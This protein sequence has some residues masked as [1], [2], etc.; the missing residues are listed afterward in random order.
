MSANGTLLRTG[1]T[2]QNAG[3][4]KA[5][6]Y[7]NPARPNYDSN[8]KVLANKHWHTPAQPKAGG[9]ECTDYAE[10]ETSTRHVITHACCGAS[11]F[12]NHDILQTIRLGRSY[13]EDC[14]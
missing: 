12:G 6:N 11:D 1:I 8:R 4:V 10:D 13:Y 7:V 5:F 2:L 3:R 14:K 9:F